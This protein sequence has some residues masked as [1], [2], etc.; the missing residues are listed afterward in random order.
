MLGP[1]GR[2]EGDVL[3]VRRPDSFE[4]AR[5]ELRQ[6]AGFAAIDGD[7]PKLAGARTGRFEDDRLAVRAPARVA[8]AFD[9]LGELARRIGPAHIGDPKVVDDAIFLE[10]DFANRVNNMLAVGAHLRFAHAL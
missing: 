2:H 8:V 4:S 10:I 1:N 5:A 3:A 7:R 9:G 6:L